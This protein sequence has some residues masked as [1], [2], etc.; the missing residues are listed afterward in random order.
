MKTT[1]NAAVLLLSILS[2]ALVSCEDD[3]EPTVEGPYTLFT[4]DLTDLTVTFRNRSVD[5]PQSYSWDFGDGQT[6]TEENPTH[7]YEEGGTYTVVLTAGNSTGEDQFQRTVTVIEPVAPLPPIVFETFDSFTADATVDGQGAAA[8]GW[9]GAWTKLD[10]D[11]VNVVSGGILNN[12]LAVESSGNALLLDA[13]GANTRYKRNFSTP[14]LDNGNTYWFAFQAEFSDTDLDGGEVQVMLVDNDAESF[15]A[16]GGD[17]QFLGIGKTITPGALGIMTFGPFNNVE[18]TTVTADGALW[19]LAKIETNGTADPDLVRLFVN[20]TPGTEPVDGTEAVSFAAPELS[21]GWQGVGFKYTG[22]NA[23]SVKIDDIYVGN[24]YQDVTPLNYLDLPPVAF[25]TFD[26]YTVDA[27]VEG[28]GAA[29]DGWSGPWARLS[30]GDVNV[31]AGGIVNNTLSI[32]TTGN[33]LL[34]DASVGATRYKRGLS[35]TYLDDGRTYWFAFQAEFAGAT[36]D[37]GELIVMLVD[38]DAEDFGGGGPNGQFL[39]IGKTISPG[40]P[41]GIMT[42]GPFNNIDATDVSVADGPLWLVAKIETN[43]TADPDLVRVF[44]NPTPGSEPAN[45]TEAVSFAAPELNGGW[46]GIGFKFNGGTTTA[47]IDDIYL[48]FRFADVTP[49]NY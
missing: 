47:K 25:E 19:L 32:E 49:A 36:D 43:G 22:G 48:G 10:G 6:S 4:F 39:G 35:E 29:E 1:F 42:F 23:S 18:A 27:T 38:N 3:N 26:S 11:D 31:E 44:V 21:G 5:G 45:G 16:G 37:T 17:G 34:L 2:L 30:G 28:Q 9:A 7:T 15:G 13:S 33:S 40:A 12:S 14:Y 20:P 41:L 8:D 46:Q 24:T